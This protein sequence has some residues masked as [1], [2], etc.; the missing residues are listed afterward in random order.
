MKR[1]QHQ[2]SASKNGKSATRKNCD[3][4][5]NTEQNLI[6]KAQKKSALQC[7]KGSRTAMHQSFTLRCLL[8]I[9]LYLISC[10]SVI[11]SKE[12]LKRGPQHRCFSVNF[13][14]FSRTP[15]FTGHFWWI[16]F[17][18]PSLESSPCLL[19][20]QNGNE[21]KETKPNTHTQKKLHTK[22]VLFS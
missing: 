7:T 13:A 9:I 5:K 15:F 12:L 10:R 14:K 22:L 16:T 19:P 3:I 21:K 11:A 2:K 17:E 20:I 18:S 4:K 1:L 6:K 8:T